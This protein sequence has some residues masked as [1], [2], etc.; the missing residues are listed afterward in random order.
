[1]LGANRG[2]PSFFLNSIFSITILQLLG[3]T[4]SLC[5]LEK[6]LVKIYLSIDMLFLRQCR[7]LILE[8]GS[9]TRYKF[10]TRVIY[11]AIY[12]NRVRRMGTGVVGPCFSTRG[13]GLLND[14]PAAARSVRYNLSCL[15]G[16][17]DLLLFM[18]VGLGSKTYR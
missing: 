14:P 5:G 7:L 3:N 6:Y 12:I 4:E 18:G 15:F 10:I 11:P 13:A 2:V 9:R 16:D 1:M 17:E 8:G